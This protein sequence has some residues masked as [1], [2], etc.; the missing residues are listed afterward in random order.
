MTEEVRCCGNCNYFVNGGKNCSILSPISCPDIHFFKPACNLHVRNVE[1]MPEQ[2]PEPK[3]KVGQTVRKIVRKVG[4]NRIWT[5]SNANYEKEED[6]YSYEL[7]CVSKV[8]SNVFFTCFELEYELESYDNLAKLE[9]E[10]VE[11]AKNDSTIEQRLST[12]EK[13]VLKLVKKDAK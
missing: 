8:N 12:L 7:H 10:L 11:N 9:Q 2:I 3:F 6:T 5:V 1:P 4:D 13:I